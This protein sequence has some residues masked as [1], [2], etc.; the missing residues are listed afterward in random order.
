MVLVCTGVLSEKRARRWNV[1]LEASGRNR[2]AARRFE[3]ESCGKQGLG[4]IGFRLGK[5]SPRRTLLHYLAVTEHD[6]GIRKRAHDLEIVTDEKIGKLVAALQL[7][8]KIDDLRLHRNVERR[9]RLVENEKFRF[10]HER[11]RNRDPLA[12]TA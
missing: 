9:G 11:T 3:L 7:A 10:Q 12:L 1:P 2:A 4:V 6:D 8:Q 5:H